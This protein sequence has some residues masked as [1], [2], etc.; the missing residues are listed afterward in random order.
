[1]IERLTSSAEG[2]RFRYRFFGAF[3]FTLGLLIIGTIGFAVMPGWT[4]SDGFYMTVITL[5]SV[6]YG[7]VRPLDDVGRIFATFLLIGGV[8]ALGIWFALITSMLVEMDL[9]HTFRKRRT[10]KELQKIQDHVIVCGAGRMGRQVI[11]ELV[12]SHTP[13][14]VI[15]KS[16]EAAE[17]VRRIDE[18]ALIVEGD[19]TLD[20]TL[21]AARIGQARG[22]VATLSA[23][24]DNL[25]VCLT[26]RD[27]QPA[28]TIASR[29][30]DEDAAGKLRKA[31]ADH[32]VSPDVTGGIRLASVL[33]R[34]QVVSFLD[35]VTR[36]ED[37]DLLLEQVPVPRDSTLD[38][39]TLAEAE[40]PRKTGLVVVAIRH[41]QDGPK[42]F[43]Y[44]P[45]PD[46]RMRSGDQLIVLGSP[47]QIDLLRTTLA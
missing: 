18:K 24:T 33:L 41:E 11:K 22:L 6:G 23:D 32:V 45:G 8:T 43:V 20:D 4:L 30:Y 31:G 10:M 19:A 47:E 21:V 16:D 46:E 28:L 38:G 29:G 9:A 2:R 36:S 40:I 14:V 39:T 13:Y 17:A 35:V 34:P 26:S 7:E 1:M 37:L 3:L 15:E 27:L 12:Q 44:N 42:R 5:S 25:F